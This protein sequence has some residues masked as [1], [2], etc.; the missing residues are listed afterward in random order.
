MENLAVRLC[1]EG[2]RESNKTIDTQ[3]LETLRSESN[4]HQTQNKMGKEP[5][6][7]N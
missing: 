7:K 4:T 1:I 3:A 2:N 6:N 5:K